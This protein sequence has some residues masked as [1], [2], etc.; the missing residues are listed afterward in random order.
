M[1]YQYVCYSI[2]FWMDTKGNAFSLDE[3]RK[4][5]II[6][7]SPDEAGYSD[8]FSVK[9][10]IMA[11]SILRDKKL[12]QETKV[13]Y[14]TVL[15][16]IRNNRFRTDQE[17]LNPKNNEVFVEGKSSHAPKMI[18]IGMCTLFYELYHNTQYINDGFDLINDIFSE[19]VNYDNKFQSYQKYDMPEFINSES[20]PYT[21]EG[22]VISIPG[23]IMEL[24]GFVGKFFHAIEKDP[25]LSEKQ[26]AD[27][28]KINS[29]LTSFFIH[30][31]RLGFKMGYGM[32]NSVSL[33][34]RKP[35]NSDMPWW[36][37]PETIRAAAYTYRIASEDQKKDIMSILADTSN[38][39]LK[40]YINDK[41][42]CMA[43]QTL[44]EFG[45]P[46]HMV[47]ATPDADPGYHTG[48]SIID[49]M[50]IWSNLLE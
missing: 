1:A 12:E 49:F 19:Y 28:N 34:T 17:N 46:I 24:V 36:S 18:A 5:K 50:N 15:N 13:Y 6:V 42:Y 7:L 3:N 22:H 32:Y 8:I 20:A 39:F 45:S 38:V 14:E 11:A 41:V 27:I 33:D 2:S 48:L 16:C 29:M 44:D 25:K 37:L 35:I 10:L 40:R 23:H 47:P 4:K 30:N 9:G 26:K 21:D 31:F 43:Y